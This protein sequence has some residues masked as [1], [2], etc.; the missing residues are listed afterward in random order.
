MVALLVLLVVL[1]RTAWVCDDAFIT[2]RTVDNLLHGFGPRWNVAERVQAY[3]HPLWMLTLAASQLIARQGPYLTS[4][5]VSLACSIATAALLAFGIA[6]SRWQGTLAVLILVNAKSFMDF[7]TS[8]LEN[9]LSHLLIVA[10]V[11]LRLSTPPA[12]AWRPIFAASLLLVNR[13]DLIWLVGPSVVAFARA[14]PSTRRLKAILAGLLP[15]LLWETFSVV[16]Y[17]FFVPNTAFAKLDTGIPERELLAQGLWYLQ[18]SW[19]HDPLTLSVVLVSILVAFAKARDVPDPA[20]GSTTVACA[21]AGPALVP[22]V[23]RLGRRRL[24]ERTIPR[25]TS[26]SGRRDLGWSPV[27]TPRASVAGDCSPVRSSAPGSWPPLRIF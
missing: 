14:I 27:A 8:G 21:R 1:V 23:R 5:L 16:Y 25:S 4:I 7:S 2:F 10:Y 22:D 20:T 13:Q 12:R 11:S 24:H 26:A 18:E 6:R 19:Q 3:T 17:G 15:L 9:A